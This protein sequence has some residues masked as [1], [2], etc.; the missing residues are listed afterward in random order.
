MHNGLYGWI[1]GFNSII[2][3]SDIAF[4]MAVVQVVTSGYRNL[5]N[6]GREWPLVIVTL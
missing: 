5:V 1:S 2:S 3:H 4:K 6:N